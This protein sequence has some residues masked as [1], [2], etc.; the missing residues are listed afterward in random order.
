MVAKVDFILWSALSV[1]SGSRCF[2]IGSLNS[3]DESVNSLLIYCVEGA[4]VTVDS[5]KVFFIFVLC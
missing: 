1:A 2:V 5:A 4:T 3:V